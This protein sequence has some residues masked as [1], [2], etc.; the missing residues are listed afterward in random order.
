MSENNSTSAGVEIDRL[1]EDDP[2]PRQ[3]FV[4]LSFVSPEGIKN[5]TIRSIKVR[6]VYAT[7]KEADE[8]ADY[9]RNEDSTFDVFVGE[10]GKWL[11]Q[12]PNPT[13]KTKVKTQ[14][15]YEKEQ[16]DLFKRR[17]ENMEKAK[18]MEKQRKDDKKIM[19]AKKAKLARRRNKNKKKGIPEK[20]K[21]ELRKNVTKNKNEDKSESDINIQE[22][23]KLIKKERKRIIN[24]DKVI[25]EKKREYSEI[26]AK[27]KKAE[28]L[29]KASLK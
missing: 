12:D 17:E 8:R 25:Q 10:V 15:Y 3:N 4:C 23:E 18:R 16:Q 20:V 5:C 9:L 13:D 2:I 11:P 6:G 22:K 7:R 19:S 27:L 24:N 28:E 1:R 26:E 14:N 29:Y 21:K